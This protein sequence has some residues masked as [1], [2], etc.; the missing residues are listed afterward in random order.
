M[1]INVKKALTPEYW[2]AFYEESHVA[3]VRFLELRGTN[4]STIIFWIHLNMTYMGLYPTRHVIMQQ[5]KG[6]DGTLALKEIA[7]A[8]FL[9][10]TDTRRTMYRFDREKNSFLYM[11]SLSPALTDQIE[12]CGLSASQVDPK[13]EFLLN[14]CEDLLA[15]RST[16]GVESY[17][18]SAPSASVTNENIKGVSGRKNAFFGK[19]V[20]FTVEGSPSD[21]AKHRRGNLTVAWYL[22]PVVTSV[23]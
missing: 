14:Y 22:P 18:V 17:E 21:Q 4:A 10:A 8:L 1:H 3:R 9:T 15:V 20:C 5:V 13:N 7:M 2:S 11:E 12:V 19:P 6:F 23:T 16:D